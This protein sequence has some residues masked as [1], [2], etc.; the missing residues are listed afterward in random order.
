MFYIATIPQ[1]IPAG[2]SPVAM[3]LLLAAIH[4]ILSL[5]WFAV[6]TSRECIRALQYGLAAMSH[7]NTSH[8]VSRQE[9]FIAV[10]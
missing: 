5:L 9:G 7:T 6:P 3:G 1:F 10:H 8:G 2:A 4:G